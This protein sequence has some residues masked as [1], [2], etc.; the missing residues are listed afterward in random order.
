MNIVLAISIIVCLGCVAFIRGVAAYNVM[1]GKNRF[2]KSSFVAAIIAFVSLVV[3][4]I[5]FIFGVFNIII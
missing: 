5:E 1:K 2:S 4:A 3:F